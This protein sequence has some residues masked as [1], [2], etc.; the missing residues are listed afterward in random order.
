MANRR[1]EIQPSLVFVS[2]SRRDEERVL[3]ILKEA[4]DYKDR[5]RIWRDKVSIP[6][7]ESWSDS[8]KA[9]IQDA[10]TVIAFVSEG[11]VSSDV[12]M[13]ME[14]PAMMTRRRHHMLHIVPVLLE[15]LGSEGWRALNERNSEGE[16]S[17]GMLEFFNGASPM[18]DSQAAGLMAQIAHDADSRRHQRGN[19]RSALE[20]MSDALHESAVGQAISHHQGEASLTTPVSDFLTAAGEALGRKVVADSQAVVEDVGIP[21]FA[22]RADKVLCGHLELKRPQSGVDNADPTKFRTP[23]DRGQWKRF[24]ELPNLLYTDGRAWHLFHRGEQVMEV[25][26]SGD[27][28]AQGAAAVSESNSR[29]MEELLR[30]FFAWQ[31]IVPK[32]PK[33][34]AETM[35]PL[36]RY[37]RQRVQRA[38][39]E[40]SSSSSLQT[41]AGEWRRYLFP[42]A[43]DEVFAD[44]YAQT[45]TFALLMARLSGER[46]L[47]VES[48]ARA[49]E[50]R[51]EPL[52][53]QVLRILEQPMARKEVA[54]AIDLIERVLTSIDPKAITKAAEGHLWLYFYEYFLA[55]YDEK[56]RKDY[57]VY[58]TPVEVVRTQVRLV[59]RLLQDG[60]KKQYGLVNDGVKVLDPACGT[61]TYLLIALEETLSAM[62]RTFGPG[63][64]PEAAANAAKN[65][66]GF[67]VLIGPYAVAHLR[68]GERLAAAGADMSKRD[69]GIYLADTLESPDAGTLG[70]STLFHERL[71]EERA[72]AGSIKRDETIL[73]CL[74]N[75][76][77]DRHAAVPH[78]SGSKS[79][80]VAEGIATAEAQSG[81]WV[82]H[83]DLGV[84]TPPIL[85]DFIDPVVK[86]KRGGDVK[87][88]YNSY[89]YF[90]RWAM[91]KVLEKSEGPGIVSFITA[92]SYLRGPG[93]LGM[94]Q[95]MR[96]QFDEIWIIDLEGDGLGARKNNNVFAIRSPCAIGIGVRYGTK[97]RDEPAAVH[98]SRIE[99]NRTEKLE[100]LDKV[101]SFESLVWQDCPSG[102]QDNFLPAAMG[103]Y[104]TWPKLT[105][106]FPWQHTGA[107]FKRTWPICPD[108]DT[109]AQRW[110][111][112][113]GE[114]NIDRRAE[115]FGETRD[116]GIG[117]VYASPGLPSGGSIKAL[118]AEDKAPEPRPYAYRALDVQWALV[119]T[120][121]GDFL[122]PVL[123][124]ADGAKQVFM[125]SLLTDALGAGPASMVSAHVPDLHHFCGRG[126]K[127]VIPLWRDADATDANVNSELVKK[128][129]ET[130]S[131]SVGP[132]DIFAYCYGILSSPAYVDTYAN[133]LANPG[134]RVPITKDT[135]LFDSTV[136]LG[137]RLIWL[138]T[139]GTRFAPAGE[140]REV[141][142][143]TKARVDGTSEQYPQSWHYDSDTYELRIGEGIVVAPVSPEV[144]TFSLSGRQVIKSW[145]DYRV[146]QGAG[147]RSSEL[148]LIRPDE[149]H[150][151]RDLLQLIAVIE[152]T[153]GMH[154]DLALN[155]A[156]VT[157]GSCF[158]DDEIPPLPT[159]DKHNYAPKVTGEHGGA[160]HLFDT[161]V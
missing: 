49:L 78:K 159:D 48:A 62:K 4:E 119:D 137:R 93:F 7:G 8:I 31:P 118:V 71:S 56:L 68:L 158:T 105:K 125:T 106:V 139:Y 29:E 34:L 64:V 126:G 134:P 35:A 60:L 36:C 65:F 145:L 140:K 6:P 33:A 115:M 142:P 111:K 148:D 107:Q 102:L 129:E 42:G 109:L 30:L 21:D 27:P 130:Y 98:Y 11:F 120:R 70:Q 2:Y 84:T 131:R 59:D 114:K 149:W 32:T 17:L 121:L 83:G 9:G 24:A 92:S 81:G 58:Y 3:A 79:V 5:F 117:G 112:L 113:V 50:G 22:I 45:L 116:R 41:L 99:G 19:L 14:V 38:L 123:W 152:A 74:G 63:A 26:L 151:N 86:A 138:H 144:M 161:D 82:R 88:L 69:V 97:N 13:N 122:K 100:A 52:L 18:D 75:P 147:R 160:G 67:E 44:G 28:L 55:A 12:I 135:K 43:D 108:K 76:P 73:V 39:A 77:W 25:H 103:D 95:H 61:G 57:G 150:F 85:A 156:N 15:P 155:L 91:W 16:E 146:G 127:D 101:V 124:A 104:A 89:V 20:V 37:L 40:Q 80:E 132:E 46:N 10:D 1:T 128:L 51:G 47:G 141:L 154:P 133:E 110:K 72:K 94:R 66:L 153:V 143:S 53:A 90:W 23:H 96:Q 54:A 136:A 157:A 87:N